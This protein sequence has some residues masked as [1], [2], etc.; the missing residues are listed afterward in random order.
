MKGACAVGQRQDNADVMDPCIILEHEDPL[1]LRIARRLEFTQN[2]L[3]D[4]QR[5]F[6]R[7]QRMADLVYE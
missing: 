5:S 7:V 2:W 6:H 3:L 4:C 1:G